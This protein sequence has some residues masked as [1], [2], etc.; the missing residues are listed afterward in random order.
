MGGESG[1]GADNVKR[2]YGDYGDYELY[3]NQKS[4][5]W[6]KEVFGQNAFTQN[7]NVNI[8]GGN[9]R[10]RFSLGLTRADEEGIMINS[11]MERNNVNL[12]L[13]TKLNDHW[14]VDFNTRFT[15]Y[16]VDGAGTSSSNSTNAFL[17]HAI[18]YPTTPGLADVLGSD[19][20]GADIETYN[21]LVNPLAVI[22]DTY[23]QLKRNTL[24]MNAAVNF[25][26]LKNFTFRS[27]WGT[28]IQ[29]QKERRY[30]GTDSPQTTNYGSYPM[31]IITDYEA[32]SYRIANTLTYLKDI[33][34]N[35]NINVMIGQEV[36]SASAKTIQN[37]VREFPMGTTIENA[38]AMM[39]QGTPQPL[40]T[41]EAPDNNMVSFFG[42]INYSLMDRYLL[43]GTFRSDG[44]SKF[45]KGNRWGHFPSIAAAW[46]VSEEAFME[47]VEFVSNLK[48][49]LSFGMAGNNRIADNLWKMTYQ[50]DYDGKHY[51][52]GEN[53][54]NQL[55]PGSTLSNPE[56]KWETTLTRN[57]GLDM[58]FFNNRLN[59]VVDLYWNTTKDLLIQAAIPA[60]TGY[61]AQM[62]N[63]GQTSNKG[64][65]LSIDALLVNK[66]D[67]TLSASFNIAFNKN[68]ID[69]LGADKS[70]LYESGWYGTQ[71]PTGEYLIQ[72]GKSTGLMY[73]YVTDGMYSFDDFNY[74]YNTGTYTLKDGI[75]SS[76]SLIGGGR[77]FGPGA[78]KLKDLNE[79]GVLDSENDRTIIGNANPKHTGGF[80][81]N[82]TWKNF[83]L[84][85]Q[86]NWSYGNDVYN[87]NKLNFTSYPGSRTFQNIYAT[88][89]SDKR[90]VTFDKTGEYTGVAGSFVTDP[91]ILAAMN[92]NATIWSPMTNNLIMHSWAVEDGSFL[93]LN[94]LTIGYTLPKS[95]MNKIKINQIR[96]YASGYN[97]W[98]WTKYTG[99]DPEVDVFSSN[100]LTPNVDY[101]AYP[102]SRTFV[103][104]ININF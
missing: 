1:T 66:R 64:I 94:N 78:L 50:S 96:I 7:Y 76:S 30:Y 75:A 29:N 56:L 77:Y 10:T 95:V 19:I 43:T 20:A 42:R 67:F 36:T 91:D 18:Q 23:R 99:Y 17:R 97:L 41:Y 2:F 85:A 6:Q 21:S 25:K 31:A 46:R 8:N 9:D 52:Y 104:G 55:R 100:P 59:A 73:G 70:L 40:Y 51:T 61:T 3:K 81:I 89:S 74:D 68:R 93:R 22:E 32:N 83:D 14:S 60:H 48:A 86:F 38:F 54:Y 82:S 11:G 92:T 57:F 13:T 90:F 79:D 80:T 72:E 98:T 39:S 49:R 26:F 33:T 87:A 88:M 53:L 62:Q 71:G 45:A 15:N 47:P 27:E 24:A 101:S 5:N 35:Q 63:I 16:V 44:S 37:E 28:E 103:G 12:N 84:T 4:T 102:R 34:P 58:G 65:E 69:K